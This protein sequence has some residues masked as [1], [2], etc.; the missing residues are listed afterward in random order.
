MLH[1]K[2]LVE[3]LLFPQQS[4]CHLCAAFS[5]SGGQICLHCQAMLQR[6]RMA[7]PF[8]P[9]N[10][11]LLSTCTSV[12]LFQEPARMLIHQLKYHGDAEVA[13]FIG[14]QMSCTLSRRPTLLEAVDLLVPVPLHETRLQERGYNQAL[15]LAEEI[16]RH[17]G[18]TTEPR[19]MTRTRMTQTLVHSSRTERLN[20]IRNVFSVQPQH[21]RGRH[22]LLI[23]DVFTTG[24]TA[25][26]CAMALTR[27]GA[28]QVSVLT[29]CRA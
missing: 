7:G 15:L 27:A 23:D 19:A 10:G 29:A 4:A 25:M 2:R 20:A 28:R 8:Q 17:T 12:W 6:I 26:A 22:I 18:L 21:V 11:S 24:A 13:A 5:D 3:K 14:E 9:P 1:A 16:S